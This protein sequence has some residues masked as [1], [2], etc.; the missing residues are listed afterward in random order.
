L[1][2]YVFKNIF[3][4]I[5]KILGGFMSFAKKLALLG[6]VLLLH[7]FAFG[8]I[9]EGE[10]KKYQLTVDQAVDLAIQGN[11]SLKQ[12][13]LALDQAKRSRDY[14][15]NSL[16]PSIRGSASYNNDLSSTAAGSQSI[17]LGLQASFALTPSIYTT[18][19]NAVLSYQQQEITFDSAKRSV[20]MSVRKAYYS[21]LYQKSY[22]SLLES[23]VTSSRN[24]YN[25]NQRKYN[26]GALAR[27]DLLSAQYAYQN[28]QTN[29]AT[30]QN[31]YANAL[32]SFK[33]IL[34]LPVDAEIT[35]EGSLDSFLNL[36]PVSLEGIEVKSNTV[37]GLEKQLEMAE[38]SLLA[39]RFS[40]YGPSLSAGISYTYAGKDMNEGEFVWG[41][42]GPNLSVSASIPLD[43][44]LPW[45]SGAQSIA[46]QKEKIENLNFQLE[47]A[48]QNQLMNIQ[49]YLN[50]IELERSNI[51][52][53][54][55]SITIA[56]Q[57]YKLTQDAY[58]QGTK[59]IL[60]LQ[61]AQNS[62]LSARVNLQLEAYN[63]A[64]VVLNLEDALGLP[65]GTF[66]K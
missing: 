32:N 43:G 52:L 63:M 18:I 3:I 49:S 8:Q 59:D 5:R 9:K 7:G 26:A 23:E 17:S 41:D 11:L 50:Q 48:K 57:T 19:Q 61:S 45:S 27:L 39:T 47:N 44:F 2:L 15:W 22:I 6:I 56:S 21:L 12:S 30:Q 38:M 4:L 29:L 16:V 65:Y 20:E 66:G 37:A 35:L 46:N 34:G 55:Q 33:Q 28:A 64:V 36:G 60:S 54:Q 1:K 24:Q 53:R 42:N 40:A 31:A 10:L 13:Q 58:N 51:A 25:T 14:S 62:L